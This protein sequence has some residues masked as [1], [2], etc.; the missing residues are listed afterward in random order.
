VTVGTSRKEELRGP[1]FD[2]VRELGF[3]PRNLTGRNILAV[4]KIQR[5]IS[6]IRGYTLYDINNLDEEGEPL[7]ISTISIRSRGGVSLQLRSRVENSGRLMGTKKTIVRTGSVYAGLGKS[8]GAAI[9]LIPLLGEKP[10]VRSLLLG[11]VT[12]NEALS[13]GER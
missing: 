6:D 3:S 9:T 5:A 12:F 13:V 8:D 4:S 7:D 2:L 10:G 11:H 1:L